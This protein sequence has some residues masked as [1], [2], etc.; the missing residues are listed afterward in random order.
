MA[1]ST[2]NKKLYYVAIISFILSLFAL[3]QDV[4]FFFTL[5]YA[6]ADK[7]VEMIKPFEII[8]TIYN[9]TYPFSI[10]ISIGAG[11]FALFKGAKGKG[12]AIAGILISLFILFVRLML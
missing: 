4:F 12:Y 9:A 8:L 7:P 2:G 11:I 5:P 1:Q 3:S 10:L 6:L